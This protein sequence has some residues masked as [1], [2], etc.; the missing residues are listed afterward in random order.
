[1]KRNVNGDSE[2]N[3]AKYVSVLFTP[4][5]EFS[6]LAKR[7]RK[8]LEVLEN[9]SNIKIKVV[10]RTGSKLTD[11]LH[12][13]NPCD[14]NYCNREDCLICN[15]TLLEH[16]KGLC[17]KR[18][19]IYETYCITCHKNEMYES[20]RLELEKLIGSDKKSLKVI[21]EAENPIKS[22]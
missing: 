21:L 11:I 15:T 4:H 5:T 16:K 6:T 13:S 8:K 10:E 12:K 19:V 1:M 2:N 7:W 18:N 20:E 17:K 3:K 9:V 14:D 22:C